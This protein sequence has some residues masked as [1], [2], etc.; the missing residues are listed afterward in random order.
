MHRRG[1]TTALMVFQFTCILCVYSLY[2]VVVV[3]G[4]GV[5]GCGENTTCMVDG[6]GIKDE[7]RIS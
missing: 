1:P 7:S 4:V 5:G 6:S 2:N 3:V